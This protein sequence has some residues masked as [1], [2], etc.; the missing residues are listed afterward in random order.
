MPRL[1]VAAAAIAALLSSACAPKE[2]PTAYAGFGEPRRVT[3]RGYDGDAMEPFVSRDGR[4]LLFNN[5]NDP[6]VNTNL[7]FA[8]RVDD[9]TFDYRGEINGVNSPALE[10]VPSLDSAGNLYFVSTRSYDQTLSTLYRGRFRDGAVTGVELVPGVSR[11]QRGSL[12]FDAEVSADGN[13]L[14]VVDGE[15]T[16]SP[17]PRSADIVIAVRDGAGFRRLPASAELLRNVNTRALEYAPAVSRD[18]LELVFTRIEG[19]SPAIWRA[20]RRSVSEPFDVPQRVAAITG[21]VE[22]PAFS[23]DGRALYYHRRE[24]K[25]HVIYRVAR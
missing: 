13:T 7:H 1:F 2:N 3:I 12:I 9:L 4:Y 25:R 16:G 8:A 24:D 6:A 22:A 17:L 23:P 15:F 18:G 5:S 11:R 21:F 19:S 10:G 20:V 14:W